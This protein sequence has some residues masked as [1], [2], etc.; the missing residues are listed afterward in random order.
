[1]LPG[2]ALGH[3]THPAIE[4][5]QKNRIDLRIPETSVSA[6]ACTSIHTV[7]LC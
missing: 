6:V 1:M 3:E 2:A 7:L 5:S 4:S